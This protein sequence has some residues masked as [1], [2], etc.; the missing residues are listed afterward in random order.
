MI[1]IVSNVSDSLAMPPFK[2]HKSGT[3][4]QPLA[5]PSRIKEIVQGCAEKLYRFYLQ[6]QS[7]PGTWPPLATVEFVELALIKQ[8]K[9]A[10]HIGL[11]TVSRDIDEVCGQKTKISFVDLFKEVD[12]GSLILFEGRP[13]SGKTTLMVKVSCDWGKREILQQAKIVILVQL[14]RLG[15]KTGFYLNELITAA[16]NGLSSEELQYLSSYIEMNCGE[17]VVFILDGFDEY[18]AYISEHNLVYKLIMKQMFSKSI[19][20]VSSRP[21]ATIFFRAHA[22]KYIEIVGF[23]KPSIEYYIHGSSSNKHKAEKLMKHLEDHPNLL[24]ICYLPLNCAMFVFMSERATVLPKT[25]TEFYRLFILSWLLRANRKRELLQFNA[26]PFLLK[27][28]DNLKPS[29]KHIFDQVCKLAFEATVN[30]KQVFSFSELNDT[31]DIETGTSGSDE[32]SL[33]LIAIDQYFVT[34]GQDETYS[35]LHLTMQEYLS[36]VY[37]SN[38]DNS[39]LM[40]IIKANCNKEHL[41]VTWHFLCGTLDYSNSDT[42]EIF[43]AI[44]DATSSNCFLHVQCAYEFQS[45]LSCSH[46]FQF[47]KGSFD[48]TNLVSSDLNL[49]IYLLKNAEYSD[50]H[51]SLESCSFSG[52]DFVSLLQA[53]HGHQVSLTLEY[54][55]ELINYYS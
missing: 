47:H 20:V 11:K 14:R 34:Y 24:N 42:E 31:I 5:D 32:S 3:Q 52:S 15:R 33:G 6:L 27:S 1:M 16:C 18:A 22:K 51:F 46:V 50:V 28:F 45:P 12:D 44:L 41:T 39:K 38:L 21:A 35:F 4:S 36:A 2:R 17:G 49:L 25:E 37:L 30:S 43:H 40:H 48:F 54:V 53:F 26:G 8:P 19:V 23:L 10:Q 13:G 29:D 7:S 9:H 55:A